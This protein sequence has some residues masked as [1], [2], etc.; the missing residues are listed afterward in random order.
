MEEEKNNNSEELANKGINSV[1][2]NI[3]AKPAVRAVSLLLI[4]LVVAYLPFILSGSTL[5]WATDGSVQHCTF[6]QYIL[7]SNGVSI[8]QFDFTLSLGEDYLFSLAYY[9]LLDPFNLIGMVLKYLFRISS[10]VTIYTILVVLKLC[11]AY[12]VMLLYL[13]HKK[14][15][16]AVQSV[17]ALVYMLSGV[18]IFSIPRHPMFA[19]GIIYL[20][21]VIW[22]AENVFENKRPYLLIL[23]AFLACLANYYQFILISFFLVIYCLIFYFQKFPPKETKFSPKNFFFCVLRVGG[24]YLLGILLLA[25][26]LLPVAYGMLTSARGSSKGISL[27]SLSTYL[28]TA[29]QYLSVNGYVNYNMIGMNIIITILAIY[30]IIKKR[31]AYSIGLV[32]LSALSFSRLFGWVMNICNYFS[33]RWFF[34]L[35]FYAIMIGCLSLDDVL[36]NG[37]DKAAIKKTCQVLLVI[38]SAIVGLG[39]AFLIGMLFIKIDFNYYVALLIFAAILVLAIFLGVKWAKK[40]H[41]PAFFKKLFRPKALLV[42]IIAVSVGQALIFNTAYSFDFWS[43]DVYYAQISADKTYVSTQNE[44]QFLRVDELRSSKHGSNSSVLNNY[45]STSAYNSSSNGNVYEFLTE[46]G[47]DYDGTLGILDL[48]GRASLEA[49][50][51][52]NYIINE[53]I[54]E[55]YG[56]S[57]VTDTDNVYLNANT[58]EFGTFFTNV[59]SEADL[60]D[61]PMYER[62]NLISEA[63]VLSGVDSNYTY[64]FQLQALSVSMT[65]HDVVLSDG[66][67]EADSGAYIDIEIT[68]CA[69]KEVYMSFENLTHDFDTNE[70]KLSAVVSRTGLTSKNLTISA[71]NYSRTIKLYPKGAQMYSDQTDFLFN[72][73]YQTSDTLSAKLSLSEGVYYFEDFSFYGYDMT[74]FQTNVD[75]LSGTSITLENFSTH[76]NSLTGSITAPSDG[77]VFMS[78]PYS[79]GWSIKVDGEDAT[80]IRADVGFMAVQLSE[81][82]HTIELSYSTPLLKEGIIISVCAAGVTLCVVVAVEVNLYIKRKHKKS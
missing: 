53:D 9:M 71:G 23:S 37:V 50:L 34:A 2:K 36:V 68:G 3:F 78:I 11:T 43:S 15:S 17:G 42:T 41:S 76:G 57:K 21:L 24:S 75:A 7:E 72:L 16:P 61:I 66:C 8:G 80:L 12:L 73:G 48:D 26:L 27:P 77:Y 35:A 79:T 44:G 10:T 31:D 28:I 59:V 22:G 6:L 81:G 65:F 55:V 5:V 46:F 70:Q 69:G 38:I 74:T 18:A 52:V 40:S 47:L 19:T 39:L 25:F 60:A 13:R 67:I 32:V 4:G 33:G 45:M 58:L 62:T 20:P 29:L 49:L 1:V 14:L 54:K 51:N 63:V 82:E 56:F 64:T 30:R